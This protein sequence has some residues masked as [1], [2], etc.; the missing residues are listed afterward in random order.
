MKK[1]VANTTKRSIL[2]KKSKSCLEYINIKYEGE[3]R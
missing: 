3:E 2:I 1:S